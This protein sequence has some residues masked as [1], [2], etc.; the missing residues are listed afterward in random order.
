MSKS[1]RH[2]VVWAVTNCYYYY[3]FSLGAQEILADA[4]EQAFRHLVICMQIELQNCMPAFL[5][6]SDDDQY[7]G[8]GK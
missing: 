7:D 4:V 2:L 6:N 8:D 5:D 1:R 3:N